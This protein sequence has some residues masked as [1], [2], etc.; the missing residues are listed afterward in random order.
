MS[1]KGA[2]A[3]DL[4][5]YVPRLLLDWEAEQPGVRYRA[6]EGTLV[7]ADVSGFT[8]LSERL[9]RAG[10]KIGAEQMTDVINAL[11]G[12]LLL[13]A[14]ARGG[15]MLKYGGD[16]VLLFFSGDSHAR[17]GV[18]AC[19][20]MQKKLAEI[21]R[22]DTGAGIV[23]LRMSVG[24]NSGTFD[25][26]KVGESHEE[27]VVA[28]PATTGCVEMEAA[29]DAT[30]VLL[31]PSAS[32]YLD[33]VC[34]GAEKSGGR[35]LRRLPK[36][37][38]VE[39]R[40]VV[41][42][43]DMSKFVPSALRSYLSGGAVEPDHRL[44]TV[45]FLH[46]M[47]L[48][49][50][51]S[52][53][54]PEVVAEDL[55]QTMAAIQEVFVQHEVSFLAT[56]LAPDGT[57]VMA[58]SGAPFAIDDP[59]RAMLAALLALRSRKPPLPVRAGVNHGHVFGGDVG[60]PFRRTYTTI[61]DVTNTAARVMGK[62]AAGE[63][64]CLRSVTDHSRVRFD[65]EP[66]PAFMA[67]GKSEPLEP[68]AVLG[69]RRGGQADP[70]L[71]F[72]GRSHEL[73][74][75][76]EAF[77]VVRDGSGTVVEVEGAPGIGKSRLIAEAA[78]RSG[79]QS[80]SVTAAPYDVATPY[81][82]V[83]RLLGELWPGFGSRPLEVEIEERA[84][85]LRA[86]TPLIGLALDR[87]ASPTPESDALDPAVVPER[88][89]AVLAA[90][91][92][93]L[94][95]EPRLWVIEDANW[96][97]EA[98]QEVLA[99]LAK[100]IEEKPLALCLSRI[101]G[102]GSVGGGLVVEVGPLSAD[103]ASELATRASHG[104][105][106]PQQRD[107]VASRAEGNPL[108]LIGLARSGRGGADLPDSLEGLIGVEIDRLSPE[109]RR[110]V[111]RLS[112][113]GVRAP[114]GVADSLLD[115]EGSVA[116]WSDRLSGILDHDDEE[117]YFRH[118]LYQEVA[119]ASLPFRR[120]HELHSRVLSVYESDAADHPLELLSV[121]AEL[122]RDD[123]RTWT[124]ASEAARLAAAK[125]AYLETATLA[126][127]ALDAARRLGRNDRNVLD[128]H[129]ALGDALRH[130]GQPDGAAA[131]YRKARRLPAL[132]SLAQ[133]TLAMRQGLIKDEAGDYEAAVRRYRSGSRALA[134][135]A[136]PEEAAIAVRLLH[137]Q[138]KARYFQGRTAKAIDMAR[139]ALA[140]AEGAGDDEGVGQAYELLHVLSLSTD[141]PE[142]SE[143]GWKA[144]EIYER[145]GRVDWQ[146]AALNNLGMEA[147]YRGDWSA[148]AELYERS[149]QNE[150]RCGRTIKAASCSAN[151][152]EIWSDQ[153]RSEEARTAFEDA[154][155]AFR[156][157]GAKLGE[158]I[159][160][161][162]LGRVAAR[163]GR[164]E[165]AH[166]H[167]ADALA[168]FTS[169]GLEGSSFAAEIEAK[170]C[171]A[172]VL[173]GRGFDAL[174]RIE[175]LLSRASAASVLPLLHRLRGYA[176]AQARDCDGA[177][178]AFESSRAAAAAAGAAYDEALAID[179]LAAVVPG[180]AVS[181]AEVAD[182]RARLAQL[183]V[184]QLLRPP[185]SAGDL[186]T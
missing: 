35:L 169:R 180:G 123:E 71:P 157:G 106:L 90:L 86:W 6:I 5:A 162:N 141:V 147:Y 13:V 83:K 46:V 21:G 81:L 159:T 28:G 177:V 116:A 29:A 61:G 166:V 18:A 11:F 115:E 100:R 109:A 12:E 82:F 110:T 79:L 24:V 89:R 173:E 186:A 161:A 69:E 49:R 107:A 1:G 139:Q 137:G 76:L 113:L 70:E 14:A 15:E 168:G 165:Q 140:A 160:L 22:V 56:D 19:W 58:A 63:I 146:A 102:A 54:D 171:E 119:Y 88:I 179:A 36:A 16:A 111:R 73:S 152:A 99:E 148:A 37:P 172:L 108:F 154:L 156:A 47:E 8:K 25:F 30:E 96:L 155:Q 57:K 3:A 27:L 38:Y 134:D 149:Q 150:Y 183:G 135:P 40:P 94:V 67:K 32:E 52:S 59:A 92:L 26:F 103:E 9:A 129:V 136:T 48:D 84:A 112:V 62:A 164:F 117:V 145:I 33:E 80:Q 158:L 45:A 126:R 121:H 151:I 7:F 142:G 174:P 17:R 74:R 75:L 2:V 64:L 176:L 68:M 23:R 43:L 181:P 131:V 105:L 95:D 44:A 114:I 182:A 42:D 97:D 55:H 85:T 53:A 120:R 93:S 77:E 167:L 125:R 65:I 122:A 175:E 66:R 178:T 124:Y 104:P 130:T 87:A 153:G 170:Q 39:F 20:E 31:S 144:L 138:A 60:P 133:A 184:V 98:S 41:T 118:P 128:L 50:R 51:L 34:L 91:L 78:A 163:A 127:R 10:G 132:D 101:A 143:A 72:I 185:L 4:T